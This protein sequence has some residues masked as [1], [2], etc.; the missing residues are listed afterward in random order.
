[1]SAPTGLDLFG[2]AFAAY[3]DQ[4]GKCFGQFQGD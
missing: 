3:S 4:Y 1:M 2:T